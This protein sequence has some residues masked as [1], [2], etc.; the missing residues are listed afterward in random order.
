MATAPTGSRSSEVASVE[1]VAIGDIP[2]MFVD[3]C[4]AEEG[5]VTLKEGCAAI[6]SNDPRV[7]SL[8]RRAAMAGLDVEIDKAIR[9]A[10]NG[11]RF[12]ATMVRFLKA[13][14]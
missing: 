3:E 2:A 10:S 13:K 12:M 1:V 9:P 5:W 11:K 6:G 14:E 8:K 7:G 4:P